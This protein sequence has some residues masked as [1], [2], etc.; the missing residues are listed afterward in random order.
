MTTGEHEPNVESE[1]VEP[2]EPVEPRGQRVRRHRHRI[3]LYAWALVLV[4]LVVV[5]IAL[6]VANTRQVRVSW[7]VGASAASLVWIV[8]VSSLLGWLLGMTTSVVFHLRTRRQ[9][10]T[11]TSEHKRERLKPWRRESRD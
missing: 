1:P 10:T 8:V 7:V 5:V 6:A 11:T 2:V 9:R 4:T 3:R